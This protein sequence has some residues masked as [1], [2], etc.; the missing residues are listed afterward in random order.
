MFFLE[1][2]FFL[3]LIVIGTA[4]LCALTFRIFQ[5]MFKLFGL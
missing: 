5:L 3:L 2:M 4:F 1:V